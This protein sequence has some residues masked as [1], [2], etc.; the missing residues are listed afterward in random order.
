[1]TTSTLGFSLGRTARY[2]STRLLAVTAAL[3]IASAPV[4]SLA[5]DAKAAEAAVSSVNINTADAATLAA[6]LQG[7][8]LARAQD[9]I[10]YREQYGPFTTV[11][12]LGEVKGIGSATLERNRARIKLD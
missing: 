1:M 5:A 8:G 10:R 4:P 6:A 12:Q 7:V 9:I 3:L 2:L 11:E